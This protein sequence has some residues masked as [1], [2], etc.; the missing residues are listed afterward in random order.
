MKHI[1]TPQLLVLFAICTLFTGLSWFFFPVVRSVAGGA[2]VFL[3]VFG[4]SNMMSIAAA[5]REREAYCSLAF[6]KLLPFGFSIVFAN[7]LVFSGA[8]NGIIFMAYENPIAVPFYSYFF[9]FAATVVSLSVLWWVAASRLTPK[10]G[11]MVVDMD[12][13]CLY[14][15]G[16][17][18]PKPPLHAK[19]ITRE[20]KIPVRVFQNLSEEADITASFCLDSFVFRQGM[21]ERGAR[22]SALLNTAGK[23]FEARYPQ[24]ESFPEI[25]RLLLNVPQD[26]P[27]SCFVWNNDNGDFEQE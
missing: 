11:T 6:P 20:T 27:G 3:S 18:L 25:W 1:F 7:F 16:D 10:P 4:F 2:F 17:E 24:V 8:Y 23:A 15:Y 22:Y 5:D 12:T 13:D 9:F 21:F 26:P 14:L 19:I